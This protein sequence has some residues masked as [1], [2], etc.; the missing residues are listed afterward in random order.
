MLPWPWFMAQP[1]RVGEASTWQRQW[2]RVLPSHPT[3]SLSGVAA[4]LAVPPARPRGRV[5]VCLAFSS[6]INSLLP[7]HP[8]NKG[9][10]GPAEPL[11]PCVRLGCLPRGPTGPAVDGKAHSLHVDP[12]GAGRAL[13]TVGPW[14]LG[15]SCSSRCE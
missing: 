3:S 10:V 7:F 2:P 13:E 9:A 5:P 8:W 14:R 12:P 15:A 6:W 4:V 11:S 1:R